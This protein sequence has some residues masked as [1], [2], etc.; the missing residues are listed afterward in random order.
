MSQSRERR[1]GRQALDLRQ[2]VGK[3]ISCT[4]A[5]RAAQC[6]VNSVALP[7]GGLVLIAP[8]RPARTRNRNTVDAE[9]LREARAASANPTRR[10]IL[11]RAL[12]AQRAICGDEARLVIGQLPSHDNA[13]RPHSAWMSRHETRTGRGIVLFKQAG[14]SRG[15]RRSVATRQIV[16]AHGIFQ[17]Q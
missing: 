5:G 15:P 10:G 3:R 13:I 11:R 2:R 8:T 7:A 14:E 1:D 6:L 17:E 9:R 16:C 4:N 12:G